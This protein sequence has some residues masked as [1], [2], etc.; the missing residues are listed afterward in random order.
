MRKIELKKEKKALYIRIGLILL[1][2]ILLSLF[3]YMERGKLEETEDGQV[4]LSR[5]EKGEGAHSLQLVAEIG[6]ESKEVEVNVSGQAYE[7]S[8]LELVFNQGIEELE[9]LILGDNESLDLVTRDLK[10]VETL[11]NRKIRVEWSLENYE[12][13]NHRG[14]LVEE[15]IPSE[16]VIVTI[17]AILIYEENRV[18]HQMAAHLYQKEYSQIEQQV[19]SLEREIEKRDQSTRETEYLILPTHVGD[20]PI[21]WQLPSNYDFLGIIILGIIIATLYALSEKQKE[22]DKKQKR[23]TQMLLDYPKVIETFTLFTGAGMSPRMAWFKI[24]E[25]YLE[26]KKEKEKRYVFEE[27]VFTM[28]EIKGGKSE[29]VCY[30]DFGNRCGITYYRKLGALI[31]ASIKKGG[32]GM[33]IH[34]RSLGEHAREE[35]KNTAKRL[36]DEAGTKL[37]LPMFLM[38]GIVLI[39]VIL[40]AFMSIQI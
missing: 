28:Y 35:R 38:L 34:L 33:A 15:N 31:A 12:Y 20:Q 19:M 13:M 24:A 21:S 23:Q 8:E 30:E 22:K 2:S 6:E 9:Q 7:R 18:I 25:T 4:I 37:M 11:F 17:E 26:Q 16:G 3:L 40:P 10:F 29:A 5:N 39:I 1:C 14:K 36:G 32:R 27:M